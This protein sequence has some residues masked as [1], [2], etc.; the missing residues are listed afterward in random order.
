MHRMKFNKEY[1]HQVSVIDIVCV[2]GNFLIF[3]F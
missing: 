1:I 3:S 2:V